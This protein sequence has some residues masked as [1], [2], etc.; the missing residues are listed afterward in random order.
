MARFVAIVKAPGLNE[1]AV[2][3][4]FPGERSSEWRPDARTAILKTYASYPAETLV[5]ECDAAD[6]DTFVSWLKK[7]GW[8]SSNVFQVNHIKAGA[9]LWKL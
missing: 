3:K 7:V 6:K 8:D 1:E 9:N 4:V 2:K 5:V